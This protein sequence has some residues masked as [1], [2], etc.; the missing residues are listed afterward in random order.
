MNNLFS[1]T[2]VLGRKKAINQYLQKIKLGMDY[3]NEPNTLDRIL[4]LLIK[5]NASITVS[6]SNA[7]QKFEKKDHFAPRQKNETQLRFT[8]TANNP[9]KKQKYMPLRYVYDIP[10][11]LL[12]SS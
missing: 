5:A 3:I 7:Q 2:E 12:P 11:I 1:Y 10:H 9:G 6:D 4:A 8:K